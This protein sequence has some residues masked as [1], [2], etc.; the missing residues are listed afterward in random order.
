MKLKKYNPL[1]VFFFLFVF[2]SPH[3][4]GEKAKESFNLKGFSQLPVVYQGR[5]CPIDTI[6]RNVLLTVHEKQKMDT[7]FGKR[8]P[9]VWL[10]DVLTGSNQE[11]SYPVF[12]IHNPAIKGLLKSKN[13]KQKHFSFLEVSPYSDLIFKYGEQAEAID[14]KQRTLFQRDI[15]KIQ[16][17]LTLY[18]QLRHT[19]KA[20]SLAVT[21]QDIHYL[22][23]KGHFFVDSFHQ[24]VDHGSFSEEMNAFM[25]K[26]GRFQF[27]AHAAPFHMIP[28]PSD[29]I[30]Q[31]FGSGV[32]EMLKPSGG[33]P[34]TQWYAGMLDA[35]H[36][37]N[38]GAFNAYLADYQ[39]YLSADPR[40]QKVKW[41]AVFNMAQPFFWGILLYLIVFILILISWLVWETRLRRWAFQ[42][43]TMTFILHTISLGF[44]MW[45]QGRPP[46]TNLYSSALFVGWVAI[47]LGLVLERLFRNGFGT[48]VCSL[49]GFC[50]LIVAHHLSFQGD[51]LEVMQAVLDSNFW[52]STHVVTIT[53][54]YGAVF[55]AGAIAVFY[56][57]RGLFSS[58]LTPELRKS[59]TKMVYGIL[60]FALF[61]SFVGTV[62]GGIWADQSWG[63]FW[64]WDPKENGALLIVL[65]IAITLHSRLAGWIKERGLMAMA[66]FGNV[67]TAFSWFGVNMLGIGLH[68]Y[69]FMEKGFLWLIGF[70]I[71][72]IIL[73]ILAM[74]PPVYW[75]SLRILLR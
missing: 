74:L 6:A 32:L 48:L 5:L 57:L 38:P 19:F 45:L 31:S 35:Y 60:C 9:M 52:L 55:L 66:V 17:Q 11:D 46:V 40:T 21:I 69:G 18:Y 56:I 49:V 24:H 4:R 59:L 13:E 43:L 54:G 44:R 72:Q 42:L 75:K 25:A 70:I 14:S 27:L 41:E 16:H 39:Q 65:W 53:I 33:S 15:L 37:H 63:R 47:G 58:S 68:S 36:N 12:T 50:T 8:P 64:G 71:S 20:D 34:G 62:L 73:I 61:F 3:I 26:I 1:Y 10:L 22:K 51:T 2:L 67:V 29:F 30:F 23:E 28:R 7:P